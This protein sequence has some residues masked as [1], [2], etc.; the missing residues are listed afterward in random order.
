MR[1]AKVHSAGWLQSAGN[2]KPA[3]VFDGGVFAKCLLGHRA[4]HK[5][6]DHKRVGYFPK[7]LHGCFRPAR[8]S[9]PGPGVRPLYIGRAVCSMDGFEPRPNH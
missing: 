7:A 9:M 8:E 5:S 4:D 2:V 1:R 6:R 3:S